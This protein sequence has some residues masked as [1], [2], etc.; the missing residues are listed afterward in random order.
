MMIWTLVRT[1]QLLS[2]L[3]ALVFA[4]LNLTE[5]WGYRRLVYIATAAQGEVLRERLFSALALFV[6]TLFQVLSTLIQMTRLQEVTQDWVWAV[7]GIWI[8]ALLLWWTW[9]RWINRHRL[10]RLVR[11]A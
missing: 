3:A 5:A 6:F 2:A 8:R 9:R 7:N 4:A 10:R 11:P 1:V